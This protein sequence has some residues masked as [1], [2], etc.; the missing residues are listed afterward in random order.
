MT[1]WGILFTVTITCKILLSECFALKSREAP[2]LVMPCCLSFFINRIFFFQRF[3]T[4][5]LESFIIPTLLSVNQFESQIVKRTQICG[6]WNIKRMLKR[7]MFR[8][9]ISVI[10]NGTTTWTIRMKKYGGFV[11]LTIIF[12]LQ[13]NIFSPLQ[14]TPTLWKDPL[15]KYS[16][17]W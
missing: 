16:I 1:L 9:M 12:L 10:L 3:S 5:L 11:N 4:H 8:P 15:C 13:W 17:T 6:L 14:A 2:F 7:C